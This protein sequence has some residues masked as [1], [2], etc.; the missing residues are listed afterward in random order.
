MSEQLKAPQP[1]GVQRRVLLK[2][3]GAA[4][5]AAVAFTGGGAWP[6]F[7]EDAPGWPSQAFKQKSLQD[8]LK[9]L[10]GKN[11]EPSGKIAL[12]VPLIAENGAV[13]PVSVKCSL[14][15]VTSLAILTPNNPY[16]LTAYYKIPPGTEAA[17]AC[18]IKMAKTSNVF[19]IAESGGKLYGASKQVKVTLGGCGG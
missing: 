14:P 6:A 13:V 15:G 10:Y 16:T 11:F 8:A 18:R 5:I 12:D 1:A 19:A 7:G 2:S 4:G 3:L 9:A 17:V